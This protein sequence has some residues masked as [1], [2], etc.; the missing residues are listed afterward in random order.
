MLREYAMPLA[1]EALK[2]LSA[3]YQFTPKGPILIEIFPVHDDF[4]VRNLGLPGTDRRARRLLRPRG[5]HGLAA[6]AAP[7]DVLVAGDAVARDRAR[8]HAA[9][10]EAA[11]AALADR[12][13]LGL[14]GGPRAGRRGA[15]TWKCRSPLAL[16]RGQ[17]LKLKDLN[18]GFTKPDTIALAY[19]QASLL[20]DHIVATRGEAALRALVRAYGDGVEGD[21][22]ITRRLASRWTQLQASF[23]KMLDAR[24][25]ALRAALRDTA[26]PRPGEAA[27][28]DITALRR[29]RAAN[30]GS[31]RAQL[32]LGPAL[33]ERRRQGGVRAARE[34]GGAG[35]DGDRRGQPARA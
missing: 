4:A 15:A 25:G 26:K 16:E 5:Q 21:A 31:Y 14:R 22:A 2:T 33:A 28:G 17:V 23:D 6:G 1:H 24:F 20:V 19:Y 35:A 13:H 27:A 29:P 10:V 8:H 18:S 12:G 34:G 11:C 32:A 7:G 9:D 30:P 3:K